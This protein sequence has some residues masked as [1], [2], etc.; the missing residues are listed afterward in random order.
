MTSDADHAEPGHD[1]EASTPTAT[2]CTECGTLLEERLA[3]G[4]LRGVC[5]NCGHVHFEDPKVAVGVIVDL[6]GKIV[7][8]R[9]AHEP[10]LGLWSFPSGYVDAG[11]VVEAAA[12]REVEEE[13][14][15]RVKLDRL[16][17]VYSRAGERIIF[18]AYAG[19][20]IGGELIAGEE[21]LEAGTFDPAALPPLAFP[22]DAEIVAAWAATREPGASP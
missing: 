6:D 14:G 11:E 19:S 8:G 10:K 7:L 3:F 17:G 5:P 1:H 12:V 9:R 2:Y 18:I 20:V 15:L 13:V 16:L 21:C 22:H 4:R